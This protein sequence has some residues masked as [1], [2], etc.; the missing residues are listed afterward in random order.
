M[1]HSILSD[2]GAIGDPYRAA[3]N[4]RGKNQ[5][6]PFQFICTDNPKVI[7]PPGPPGKHIF[8]EP[9]RTNSY[10]PYS[11]HPPDLVEARKE[12]YVEEDVAS[13]L[14]VDVIGSHDESRAATMTIAMGSNRTAPPSLTDLHKI[15]GRTVI[16]FFCWPRTPQLRLSG[17]AT[18]ISPAI[19]GPDAT[20]PS[21]NASWLVNATLDNRK[22]W[23]PT[24]VVQMDLTLTDNVTHQA[25]AWSMV[26]QIRLQPRA[27]SNIQMVVQVR[28]NA[29]NMDDLTFQHL[30]KACGLQDVATPSAL[31]ITAEATFHI[32]GIAWK[33]AITV[34]PRDGVFMCP[35]D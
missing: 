30:Y 21:M 9:D 4:Q 23:V 13:T 24:Q 3:K 11:H 6:H 2:P 16:L 31:N 14:K 26:N 10:L 29:A 34:R 7:L 22:N 28:Y 25:F 8:Q 17:H 12:L 19:W 15:Q 18:A 33:P 32:F 35:S 20:H 1:V 5:S 27:T